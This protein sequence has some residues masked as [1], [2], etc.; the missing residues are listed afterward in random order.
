LNTSQE[1]KLILT[2]P[3]QAYDCQCVSIIPIAKS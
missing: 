3:S 2:N 1:D